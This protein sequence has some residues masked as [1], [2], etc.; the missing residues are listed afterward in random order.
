VYNRPANLFVAQFVG[1]PVMNVSDVAI[2]GGAGA[3]VLSFG[4][5]AG[6]PVASGHVGHLPGQ[7]AVKL[8]VRPEAVLLRHEAAAGFVE[9]TTTNVEPLGSHE[10]VDVRLGN[11]TL[12][13]R[14]EPGFVGDSQRVW[15]GLDP[16]RAHFFDKESGLALRR[17]A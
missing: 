12:R 17:T 14:V 10:I 5:G 9:T 7:R 8:G 3:A 6:I 13:A 11:T 2:E 15:V 4:P 16:E 1:S